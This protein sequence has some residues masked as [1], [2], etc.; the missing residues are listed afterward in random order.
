MDLL[1]HGIL[2]DQEALCFEG[3][4]GDDPVDAMLIARV[5]HSPVDNDILRTTISNDPPEELLAD[6]YRHHLIERAISEGQHAGESAL[7]RC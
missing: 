2:G 1:I 6:E 7:A 4:P 3:F 5:L